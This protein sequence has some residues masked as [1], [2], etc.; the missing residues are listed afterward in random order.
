MPD[1]AGVSH[2]SLT[3]TDVDRSV[4]W[5]QQVLGFQLLMPTERPGIKGA[6][7]VHQGSGL[8]LSFAQH[9]AGAGGA[10]DELRTGLD[11]LSFRAADRDAVLAWQE[12]LAALD[13]K[14]DLNDVPYGAV[15]VFRDPDDIQLEVF[16]AAPGLPL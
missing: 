2:I 6:I 13:V 11:H 1:L 9:E 4:A 5:Y 16:A 3:V 10:F 14:A 12:H 8:L 7:L 15:L